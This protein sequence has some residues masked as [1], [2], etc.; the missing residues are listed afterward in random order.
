M[1]TVGAKKLKEQCLELLDNPDDEGLAVTKHGEPVARV[2]PY[3]EYGGELIGSLHHKIE[4][5]GDILTTG[6]RRGGDTQS[7]VSETAQG[8]DRH[9][10]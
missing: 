10:V 3:H 2:I 9:A 6:V 8:D 1:N 7:C 4:V 5:R